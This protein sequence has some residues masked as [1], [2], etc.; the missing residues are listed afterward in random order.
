MPAVGVSRA[1]FPHTWTR[2]PRGVPSILLR[3]DSTA[4]PPTKVREP[5][6]KSI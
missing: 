6:V 3:A 4:D 1:F 2:G 5:V